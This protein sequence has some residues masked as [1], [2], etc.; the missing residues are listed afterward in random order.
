M[1][2][3]D[4]L[5]KSTALQNGGKK[6]G[7][8]QRRIYNP[9]KYLCRHGTR[10]LLGQYRFCGVRALWWKIFPLDTKFWMQDSN[11]VETQLGP[12]FQNQA[13]F[14]RFS[15]K[16]RGALTPLPSSCAPAMVEL[17][18]AIHTPWKEKTFGFLTFSDG[19]ESMK[20]I[21]NRS[22]TRF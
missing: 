8:V 10:Y 5:N 7:V 22:L 21:Y 6:L 13:T 18:F 12:F 15:K 2:Q 3:L 17:F 4:I 20:I 11:Q 9:G 16:G 19:I 1:P 14:F